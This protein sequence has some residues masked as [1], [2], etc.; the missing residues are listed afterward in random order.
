MLLPSMKINRLNHQ[1]WQKVV[2]GSASLFLNLFV[3]RPTGEHRNLTLLIKLWKGDANSVVLL[4]IVNCNVKQDACVD[5]S[6]LWFSFKSARQLGNSFIAVINGLGIWRKGC[7]K[8]ASLSKTKAS[9][10]RISRLS[11]IKI[12]LEIIVTLC[13]TPI[14]ISL[15]SRHRQM[16]K[17]LL[18]FERT[19]PSPCPRSLVV[20]TSK[21]TNKP[22]VV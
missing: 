14:I 19:I 10:S 9:K 16:H 18:R 8:I 17:K 13:V 11:T 20:P 6:P 22:V 5:I 1:P 7:G 21:A 3:L 4:Q 15:Q 2:R 12:Y